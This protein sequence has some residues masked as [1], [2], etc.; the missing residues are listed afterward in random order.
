MN[1]EA[2]LQTSQSAFNCD[3]SGSGISRRRMT[4]R[5]YSIPQT[6]GVS[7]VQQPSTSSAALEAEQGQS[8]GTTHVSSTNLGKTTRKWGMWSNLEINAFYDGIKQF[9]KDFDQVAKLMTKKKMNKDK[10]QIRNYYYNS[11]KLLRSTA[12]FDDDV[13]GEFPRDARELFIIINGFEWKKRTEDM[14][15]DPSKLRQLVLEG[16]TSVRL[17]KKKQNL[18]IR[19]PFCPSLQKFFPDQKTEERL[20]SHVIIWFTPKTEA[21]RY[22]VEMCGQNPLLRVRVSVAERIARIFLLLKAKWVLRIA[23]QDI[24]RQENICLDTDELNLTL[25]PDKTTKIGSVVVKHVKESASS[26]ISLNRL[27]KERHLSFPKKFG[28]AEIDSVSGE[29]VAKNTT[30]KDIENSLE[31]VT[32]ISEDNNVFTLS[33]VNLRSGLTEKIV[34]NATVTELFYLC[35]MERDI[36]LQYSANHL[37]RNSTEP[38]S[39]FISLVNRNYGENLC[40]VWS[41]LP[42]SDEIDP[43]NNF[44]LLEE[45]TR[46]QRLNSSLSSTTTNPDNGSLKNLQPMVEKT[47]TV[48]SNAVERANNSITV[49]DRVVESE[50]NAFKLQFESMQQSRKR[51]RSLVQRGT[52]PKC[53]YHVSSQPVQIGSF[54]TTVKPTTS[55]VS[56]ANCY[57][58]SAQDLATARQKSSGHF[59]DFS[60]I[61]GAK[62]HLSNMD[63]VLVQQNEGPSNTNLSTEAVAVVRNEDEYTG[64][65]SIFSHF[66][67]IG[68]SSSGS[69]LN[70]G[71]CVRGGPEAEETSQKTLTELSAV[72][73]SGGS[74][75]DGHTPIKGTNNLPEDV[76]YSFEMMMQQNSVDYC[77]NF[78]Q[79]I[80]SIETPKKI[81]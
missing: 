79:L 19:T 41:A 50:N 62:M 22:Y 59:I 44:S 71:N 45:G 16:S 38:W 29:D 48:V 25:Y 70:M 81:S 1:E 40:K 46:K 30:E 10:D 28:G 68:G 75:Q 76:R 33:P 60:S 65:D 20:P 49:H 61:A 26:L 11:F 27:K 63:E 24:F 6:V 23:K 54:M 52:P 39:I 64:G 58:V 55:A 37:K 80:T 56:T 13:I 77:R 18:I 34:G 5:P 12:Q 36:H 42:E 66:A 78:E 21:D 7:L 2:S 74:S 57:F 9:G 69:E 17:K 3:S 67:T 47:A 15:I 43:L 8:S 31:N 32:H 73:F 72:E 51:G 35:G 4:F 53:N 14:K